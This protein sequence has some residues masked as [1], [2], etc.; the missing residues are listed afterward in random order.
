MCCTDKVP[1][2]FCGEEL[3]RN[4]AQDNARD[5][6]QQHLELVQH[7]RTEDEVKIQG[8]GP[9]GGHCW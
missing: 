1:V 2:A 4:D 8:N 9:V 6:F 7:E 5:G 3:Q